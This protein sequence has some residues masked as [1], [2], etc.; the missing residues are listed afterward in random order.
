MTEKDK[1]LQQFLSDPRSLPYQK[2]ASLLTSVWY[3]ITNTTGGSHTK[4]QSPDGSRAY[5]VP[6]HHGDCKEFYKKGLKRFYLTHINN[7]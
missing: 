3:T 5:T 1:I 6:L 4:V 2:I 7:D